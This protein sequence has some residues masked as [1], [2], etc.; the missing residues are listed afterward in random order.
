[1]AKDKKPKKQKIEI[2]N[3]HTAPEIFSSG[4]TAVRGRGDYF[5]VTLHSDRLDLGE[6]EKINRVVAAHI[7]M[8]PHG[9]VELY[10]HLS[11]IVKEL[12]EAGLVGNTKQATD[13]GATN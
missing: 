7:V 1:M 3:S 2:I 6:A 8:S 10:N 4:A 13:G 9:F 5:R 12:K 11:Y